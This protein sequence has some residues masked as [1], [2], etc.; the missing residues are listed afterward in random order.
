MAQW[1]YSSTILEICTYTLY[2]NLG[3]LI[4]I[5]APV[6]QFVDRRYA[7]RAIPAHRRTY[8]YPL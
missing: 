1:R 7:N 2:R 3:A 6:V 8:E 4:K 5:R